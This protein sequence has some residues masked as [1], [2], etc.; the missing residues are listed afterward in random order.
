MSTD[1]QWL[2]T[3]SQWLATMPEVYDKCL[4]PALFA[5][6][7]AQL[8]ASVATL[9]PGRVLELA[10]GTGALTAELVRVLPDAEITAT[11]LNP[12]MVS[13]A[14]AR[15]PGPTWSQADAQRLDLPDGGFDLVVC[16][17]GVMFFPDKPAAFAEAARVLAPGATL[18]FTVWDAVEASDFPAA[19][20]DSLAAVLPGDLPDF[21]VRVPHGYGDPVRIT[22]DLHTG[23]LV[24]D[25]IERVVLRGR[26]T[27]QALAEGFCLGTPLRFALQERGELEGLTRSLREEMITR[28]GDGPVEGDLAAYLVSAHKPS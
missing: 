16:Q 1:S 10:A 5:P 14:A 19:L 27:A 4:A 28:L 23:G 9:A 6:F 7:A 25:S 18:L 3:D 11:D 8:A 21:V 20:V 17:F 12:A 2:A 24:V 22:A 13:W 26:S 15:I